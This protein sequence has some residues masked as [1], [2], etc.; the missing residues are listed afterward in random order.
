MARTHEVVSTACGGGTRGGMNDDAVA[1]DAEPPRPSADVWGLWVE[2]DGAGWAVMRSNDGRPTVI[3]RH[4]SERAA[5]AA[6][7]EM[8]RSG[9]EDRPTDSSALDAD[10]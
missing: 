7:D 9:P 8:N 10:D 5:R 6:V 1:D 3:S 2:A 4:R